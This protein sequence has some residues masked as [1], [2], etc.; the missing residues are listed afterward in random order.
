MVKTLNKRIPFVLFLTAA[1]LWFLFSYQHQPQKNNSANVVTTQA[2][3][4]LSKK[5]NKAV[6]KIKHKVEVLNDGLVTMIEPKTMIDAESSYLDIYRKYQWAKVCQP[7]LFEKVEHDKNKQPMVFDYQSKFIEGLNAGKRYLGQEEVTP[8]AQL[9]VLDKYIQACESVVE[10]VKIIDEKGV[11][12]AEELLLNLLLD[13]PA[14]SQKE[15]DIKRLLNTQNGINTMQAELISVIES[16]F[17]GDVEQALSPGEV[18]L[19]RHSISSQYAQIKTK[20]PSKDFDVFMLA[21]TLSEMQAGYAGLGVLWYDFFRRDYQVTYTT[22]GE[23]MMRL[24]SIKERHVFNQAALPAGLL[25]LCSLGDDCSAN[26]LMMTS[27]CL[28]LNGL[29]SS[30]AS[31]GKDLLAFYLEGFVTPNLM[32]D[33]EL[34]LELMEVEYGS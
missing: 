18:D 26:G 27:Y 11:R 2:G 30:P 33:V 20:L 29:K 24:L 8:V 5:E 9:Q 21:K 4:E 3:D 13:F 22:P 34:I 1:L 10:L 16:S 23:E 31:C 7:Y 6:D 14:K 25:Y 15:K 12:I 28:G 17:E 32:Q 19:M